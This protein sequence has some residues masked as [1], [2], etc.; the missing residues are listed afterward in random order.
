MDKAYGL[1][2]S[3][4]RNPPKKVLFG[5]L[6]WTWPNLRLSLEKRPKVAVHQYVHRYIHQ[7]ALAGTESQEYSFSKISAIAI[8][9]FPS[10]L[11]ITTAVAA[12]TISSG[13][14]SISLLFNRNQ[15][16]IEIKFKFYTRT[17]SARSR[18]LPRTFG[19]WQCKIV[20]GVT[21]STISQ[22]LHVISI[23]LIV[24]LYSRC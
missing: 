1:L 11:S 5:D 8:R 4:T 7:E 12:A 18:N 15:R 10:F 6:C 22:N 14:C 24:L 20:Q 13:F 17:S 3:C 21:I 2:I 9:L 23:H 16:K 19:D